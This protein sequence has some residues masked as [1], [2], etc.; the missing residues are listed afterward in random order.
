MIVYFSRIVLALLLVQP[1]L[2]FGQD[3][4]APPI[5]LESPYNTILVHLYYL[6][7][8]SYEPSKAAK[9]FHN[10]DSSQAIQT[11]IQL[12]QVLDGNG[13]YVHLNLVPQETDY[14]D[15]ISQKAFYTPFPEELPAVYLEKEDGK[16]YYSKS[17]VKGVPKLHKKVYPFG[18]NF[19]VDRL[20]N[21]NQQKVFGL[22]L[23]QY[24]SLL[25]LVVIGWLLNQG[26]K[27]IVKPLV[28]KILQ[29]FLD[30]GDRSKQ[31]LLKI[32]SA[33]SMLIIVYVIRLLLPVVQ[34]PIE[35]AQ[36]SVLALRILMTVLFVVLALRVLDLV[37]SFFE[38]YA[39]QTHHKMDEQLIPIIRRTFWFLFVIGG[40]IQILR[41]LD[42][43]VTALIAGISIGGLALA[44]A[45][46]DTVKN[47]IGSLMIFIDQ[48]FQIDDYI[49]W[50]GMAGTVVEVGFRTTRIKTSDTSII[51]VPNGTIANNAITNKGMRTYRLFRGELGLD[52][53]T[54]NIQIRSF[55]T[56]VKKILDQHP[57]VVEGMNLV[58][59]TALA[60]SSINITY[61][62]YLN[63]SDYGEELA[64]KEHLLLTFMALAEKLD[65]SFAYPSST[66][67][68]EATNKKEISKEDDFDQKVNEFIKKLDY[69][70]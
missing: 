5:T 63:L 44:L 28:K 36:F 62:A 14:L 18:T 41:L 45:A 10:I 19:I 60:D 13:L 3:Q 25:I 8:D 38:K 26:L 56:G 54:S 64:V 24:L 31:L 66:V 42:V 34:L 49:E 12:K 67:Y 40:A 50:G 57:M 55:L 51:A 52:Y 47:L 23:W 35:A 11:A 43:N 61:R 37:M 1:L 32:T 6:Q 16:W 70:R 20:K 33:V 15:S 30:E 27:L 46:Q 39:Q 2:S 53:N 9:V 59:L 17:T 7:E 29:K 48:P 4:S 69:N 68:L 65:I 21:A 58:H 22:A